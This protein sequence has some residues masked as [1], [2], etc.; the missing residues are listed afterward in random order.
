MTLADAFHALATAGC[1]F[2]TNHDGGIALDVPDGATVAHEVLD[3]LRAHRD[4]LAA[5]AQPRAPA[6][7]PTDDLTDYLT[8]K[9]ITGAAAELVLHAA[10]TFEVRHD[11]ITVEEAAVDAGPVLFEPG[12]PVLT[13]IDTEWNTAGR[14]LFTIP[15]GTLALVIPQV[16]AIASD[17]ERAGIESMLEGVRR[18]KKPPHVPLWLEGQARAVETSTITFEGAVAPDGMNLLPWRPTTPETR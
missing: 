8:G 15:A 17:F 1:R 10:K 13:T 14:G 11:R 9:G 4:E 5:L 7:V 16:W 2:V 18:H 3:V 6:E 12:I